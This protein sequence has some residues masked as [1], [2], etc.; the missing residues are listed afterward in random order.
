MYV[1]P[2][3]TRSAGTDPKRV[4]EERDVFQPLGQFQQSSLPTEAL[5]R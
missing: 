4:E 2:T 3:V 1:R 5:K